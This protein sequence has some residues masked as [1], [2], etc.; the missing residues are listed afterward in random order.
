MAKHLLSVL[1]F[2][3]VS[4]S[5][6][7]LSHFVINKEYFAGISFMRNDPIMPMGFTTMIIQ[8]LIM[9]LAVTRLAPSGGTVR[10]GV[11]VS[12]AFGLFLAVYIALT[13]P[14]KYAA[15]SISAW[16]MVEGLASTIQFV[17]FGF[18]LGLI[19]HKLT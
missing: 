8:G 19:H 3:A 1:A 12:L 17:L 18:L 7:G 4:F 11:T 2:I 13:E 5:V 6:Q 14:A 9:S 15:P 10:D 16:F